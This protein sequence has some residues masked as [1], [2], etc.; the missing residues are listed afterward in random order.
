MV[1]PHPGLPSSSNILFVEFASFNMQVLICNSHFFFN[2]IIN[3]TLNCVE[4]KRT[5]L[6]LSCVFNQCKVCKGKC[7]K[8]REVLL[9]LYKAQYLPFKFLVDALSPVTNLQSMWLVLNCFAGLPHTNAD[10][11]MLIDSIVK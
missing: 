7:W 10:I 9:G 11:S 5:F 6:H 3:G 4:E 1:L 8:R 2:G